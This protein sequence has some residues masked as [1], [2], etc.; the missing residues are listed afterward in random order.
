MPSSTSSSE[1]GAA[2]QGI[3]QREGAL[4]AGLRLTASDRPGQAQPIPT[5]DVPAQPWGRIL[6]G[7][8]A[9]IVVGAIGLEVNARERIG[10]H[11][12][13][14][15]NSEISWSDEKLR[16]AGAPTAIVG[17]SRILFDTDLDR[18]EALTGVRPIQLAI[19]GTSALTLL[20]NMADDKDFKGV[21][22]VGLADTMF[23]QPFDGYGG[24][25]KKWHEFRAPYRLVSN[26]IDHSLQRRIAFLDS[27]YR[28]SVLAHRLDRDFRPGVEGPM[29]DIWKLQEVGEHR[30]THLWDRVEYD[31]AWR[32]RTRWA[33]K[34]FK[35]KFPY[36]PELIAKGHARAKVA[37]D[38][39]RARGGDVVFIRPPS[40]AQLRVNEEAQVP[41]AKGWDYLLSYTHSVGIHSDE[42]PA[43]VG[44]WDLP[45]WSHLSRTCATVY[46]D[47]YVRRLTELI[48]RLKLRADAPRPLSQADCA[49]A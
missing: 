36:T 30:A 27:N 20:E 35:D 29:D 46:T 15:D 19:H 24:Y 10:L 33:W 8:L 40:A 13:D 44:G 48:P 11:A 23:F 6:I 28:L 25:V 45:E 14:L 5:R 34:G 37:V 1:P 22:I 4:P 21:L 7:V 2:P 26:E 47:A 38:K 32:A 3:V 42:L 39:I 41:K 9:A 16:A 17:D 43:P 12:G 18:F 49:S 31:H